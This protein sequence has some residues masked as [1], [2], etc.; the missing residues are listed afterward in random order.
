MDR[1]RGPIHPVA[2]S[3]GF[4]QRGFDTPPVFM[5]P[6]NPPYYNEF[7]DRLG[8]YSINPSGSRAK[9]SAEVLL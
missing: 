4:L 3:W 5:A 9:N 1:V 6:Y 7:M 2:E 8:K